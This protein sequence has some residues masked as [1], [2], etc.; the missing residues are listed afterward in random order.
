MHVQRDREVSSF[1]NPY[2]EEENSQMAATPVREG[3]RLLQQAAKEPSSQ[4]RLDEMDKWRNNLAQLQA[5]Y[6]RKQGQLQQILSDSKGFDP[7][8]AQRPPQPS[9]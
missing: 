5:K 9:K 1:V 7:T 6:Q 8:A 4:A 3:L 2:Y